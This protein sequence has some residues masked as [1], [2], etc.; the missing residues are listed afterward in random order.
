MT[1]FVFGA[2]NLFATPL[3]DTYGNTITTPSPVKFGTL[4][5]ISIDISKDVK[6][7][8][9]QNTFPV[10]VAGGKGKISIKAKAAQILAS[11]FNSIF[12]GQTLA[13]GQTSDYV[14][15][16]GSLIPTT[17]YQVTPIPPSSGTWSKDLGV[18]NASGDP[19]THVASAPATGQYSVS[20]GVYTFAAADTGTTV[21]INYQYTVSASGKTV[22]VQNTAM[23]SAPVFSMDVYMQ[24]KGKTLIW[25]FP[26]CVS[27][28]L[29][30]ATKLDDYA[31]PEFDISAFANAAGQVVTFSSAE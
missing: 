21:F 7:L 27:T 14:D 31:I 15:T 11:A 9:G 28:K 30:I 20:A 2:G 18:I 6:E 13:T 1:Q 26:Q 24:N 4:Q 12:F 10:D 3:T 23:G 8:Y 25:T 17:P 16:T 19:L 5:D 29:T 22:I